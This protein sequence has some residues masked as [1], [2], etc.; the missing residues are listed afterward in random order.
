MDEEKVSEICRALGDPNRLTIITL[1]TEG[2]QCGCN[3]L[4]K[5]QITQPTLSHHMKILSDTGLVKS[6]KDGK[7]TLY[8]INCCQFKAFKQ[9][10]ENITCWKDQLAQNK[11]E[12][13]QCRTHAEGEN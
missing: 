4:E 8:E 6:R 2:E 7:K 1:L 3:L 12:N 10:F 5:F 13:C 9:Y 11:T